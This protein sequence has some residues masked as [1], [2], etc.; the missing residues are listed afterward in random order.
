MS[1]VRISCGALVLMLLSCAGSP[2][3]VTP[4]AAS[5]PSLISSPEAP[6]RGDD[7]D[8]TQV[9]RSRS[10]VTA[11]TAVISISAPPSDPPR[12]QRTKRVDVSF[13]RAELTHALQ[14]LADAGHFNLIVE[15]GLK[16]EVNASLKQV[17]PYDAL[18]V[19]ARANGADAHL[20]RG[21]VYVSKSH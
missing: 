14:V 18:L 2:E 6:P 12:P 9:T 10:I 13:Q 8:E 17:D 19:I 15:S 4:S 3:P 20:E 5:Q 21:I 11:K 16:G 7:H 1:A